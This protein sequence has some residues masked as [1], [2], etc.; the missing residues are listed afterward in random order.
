ME[1]GDDYIKAG[2]SR[3]FRLQPPN[4]S[5]KS[6]GSIERLW[7]GDVPEDPSYTSDI[8]GVSH[9]NDGQ[10]VRRKLGIGLPRIR[11]V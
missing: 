2:V 7:I 5:G 1:G 11:C 6:D 3:R 4:D 8:V 10:L 9:L